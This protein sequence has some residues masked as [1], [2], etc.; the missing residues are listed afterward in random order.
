MAVTDPK[1]GHPTGGRSPETRPSRAFLA[2][3]FGDFGPTETLRE[4]CGA[5]FARERGH[6]KEAGWPAQ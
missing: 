2:N 1:A 6:E 5:L 3:G 4:T